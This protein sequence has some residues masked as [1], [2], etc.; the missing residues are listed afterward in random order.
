MDEIINEVKTTGKGYRMRNRESKLIAYDD[1]VVLISENED[2][3]QRI[4]YRFETTANKIQ[5]E[6]LCSENE[7][8]PDIN[9]A[10]SM[11]IGS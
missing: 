1:N 7:I 8:A 11:Q 4:V 10:T 2:N 9:G 5:S 3:L 6:H